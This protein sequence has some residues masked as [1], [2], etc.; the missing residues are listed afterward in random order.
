MTQSV[1]QMT[2]APLTAGVSDPTSVNPPLCQHSEQNDTA[3]LPF[4]DQLNLID[5]QFRYF[6]LMLTM[7]GL[8]I[9][10]CLTLS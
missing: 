9:I 5:F 10:I 7:R 2:L 3:K 4:V 8:L 1:T 6:I